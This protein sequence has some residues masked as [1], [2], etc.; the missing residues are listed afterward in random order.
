MEI[1]IQAKIKLKLSHS[2]SQSLTNAH[3]TTKK[4]AGG[5]RLLH[6]K[7][8]H[9]D[10]AGTILETPE[11]KEEDKGEREL[12]YL[13][14]ASPTDFT[15]LGSSSKMVAY[16]YHR[17]G[18]TQSHRPLLQSRMSHLTQPETQLNFKTSDITSVPY[19]AKE[20]QQISHIT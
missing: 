19:T 8:G 11:R 10:T 18:S 1:L 14:M 4:N 2:F 7:C 16:T 15:L 13:F 3:K 5:K 17:N 9:L 20:Q 12:Q 6:H